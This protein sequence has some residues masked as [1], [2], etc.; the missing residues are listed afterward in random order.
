MMVTG[1]IDSKFDS[2][3]KV[4]K[5]A[6]LRYVSDSKPGFTR[7]KAG[8]GFFYLDEKGGKITENEILVRLKKLVLPPAWR[9]IW[10]SPIANGHL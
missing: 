1:C 8:K 3:A 9:N 10:I 2:P 5:L 4:A 7:K 6:G